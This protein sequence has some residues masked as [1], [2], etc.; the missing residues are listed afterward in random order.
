M[1]KKF[2]YFVFFFCFFLNCSYAQKLEF[3]GNFLLFIEA[4]TKEPVLIIQDSILYKGLQPVRLPFK[5]TDYLST[6]K[7]Y[8]P[9][10]I[11]DKTYLVHQGC[12]PVLEFRNDSI[13]RINDSYLQRNQFGAVYFVYKNEIYFFGGYGLFTTKNILTKYI[14]KT[15]DWVQ[16]QTRGEKV[17]EPRLGAYSYLKGD[18]LYVFGGVQQDDNDIPNTIP[19]DNRVWCLHLPTMRWDCVGRFDEKARKLM[20]GQNFSDSNKIVIFSGVFSEIDYYANT[21]N[22]YEMN[23]FVTYTSAY[24]EGSWIIGVYGGNTPVYCHRK[25]SDYKGKLI[26]TQEFIHPL[27]KDSFLMVASSISSAVLILVLFI[28][29]KPIKNFVLP[30]RGILYDTKKQV[31]LYKGKPMTVFDEQEK[32]LLYFLLERQEEYI[33]LFELHQ[34]FENPNKSEPFSTIVKRREQVIKGF[35]LKVSKISGIDEKELVL[36][37]K[38][39]EDK[40]IKDLLLL[41]NLLKKK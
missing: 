5:H 8:T 4:K 27:E 24:I 36:E 16:V 1:N 18:D 34:L 37:T 25:L 23:N 33:S 15:K 28:F 10:L 41:P 13:V 30:F 21:I 40:R 39:T 3:S 6:L 17:Q 31:F 22:S 19:L 14:F 20:L 35:L 26:S 32:K 2:L 7:E 9:L 11:Q 29:R 38:N 12:G